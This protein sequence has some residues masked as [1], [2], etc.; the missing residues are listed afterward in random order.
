M[1]SRLNLACGNECTARTDFELRNSR[2]T[3]IGNV[4]VL[5]CRVDHYCTRAI[6]VCEYMRGCHGNQATI[7]AD[8]ELAYGAI[9]LIGRVDI[10]TRR[11]N[12]DAVRLQT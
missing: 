9:A 11:V 6:T 8:G 1:Q 3:A 4:D 12:R 10:V 7:V 5:A 2:V